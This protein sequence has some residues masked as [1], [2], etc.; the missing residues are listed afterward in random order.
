MPRVDP[1]ADDRPLVFVWKRA[2][3]ND[4][5]TFVRN[6][7]LGLRSWRGVGVGLE[8]SGSGLLQDPDDLVLHE[9]IT[10]RQRRSFALRWLGRSRR[11]DALVAEH[12]PA[13]I[14]AHFLSDATWIARYARR[15]GIPLVVT[16]HGYDATSWP[17]VTGAPR[18]VRPLAAAV[19]RHQA[20]TVFRNA[21][22]VVAVSSFIRAS[23]LVLGAPPERTVVRYIGIPT[24]GQAPPSDSDRTGIVFVG[25]LF[26]KKGVGDLLDAVASLPER[27]RDVPVTIVGEGHLRTSLMRRAQELDLPQVVFAGARSPS[28]VALILARAAVFCAPSQT[29]PNGDAEGFGMVY[30]EAALAAT[31]V[32]SYSHGGVTEAVENGVTGLLVAE[33]DVEGLS[34]ALRELLDDPDRART[35]GR[36]GR[37]RVLASFDLAR[38]IDELEAVYDRAVGREAGDEA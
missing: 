27:L 26:E 15:R 6:Q 21:C 22:T 10:A 7:L 32:L 29:A 35:M 2:W 12:R 30:L 23:L 25:R 20:R 24:E 1:A 14:H 9:S 13:L 28:E 16:A 4:S 37:D 3:L 34:T 36:A 19:R 8:R 17:R 33:R 18:V 31:P 38:R 5:E 11:L